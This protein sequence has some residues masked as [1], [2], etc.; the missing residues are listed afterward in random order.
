MKRLLLFAAA[1]QAGV[2]AAD[3]ETGQWVKYEGAIRL[4]ENAVDVVQTRE[5]LAFDEEKQQFLERQSSTVGGETKTTEEWMAAASYLST[6]TVTTMLADCEGSGGQART[7][8]VK[9]EPMETCAIVEDSPDS[10]YVHY[11]AHVPFSLARTTSLRKSDG[12]LV[13]MTLADWR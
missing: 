2:A 7:V 3:P 6:A 12:L 13:D 11:I 4:Y 5:L 9:G 8:V 1:M 10:A